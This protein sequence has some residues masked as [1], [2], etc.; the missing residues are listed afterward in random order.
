MQVEEFDEGGGEQVLRGVLLHVIEA[1][2]P[3][4][5][6]V[7][8]TGWNF[9]GGV[10]NYVMGIA[11]PASGDWGVNDFYDL[12]VA[13][14]ACVVRLAAGSRVEGGLIEDN[15][16]AGAVGRAGNNCGVEF[17]EERVVV[18]EPVRQVSSLSILGENN[19]ESETPRGPTR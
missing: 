17:A 12:R 8:G 2:G 10:V 7:D 16:P 19:I 3:V 18:I 13:E 5:L 9:G 14:R 11:R 1:A 4:N 15:F 6:A